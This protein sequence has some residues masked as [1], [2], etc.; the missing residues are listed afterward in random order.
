MREFEKVLVFEE[1]LGGGNHARWLYTAI[2]R[3]S[4]KIVIVKD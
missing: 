1:R 2:T 4:E 3:A